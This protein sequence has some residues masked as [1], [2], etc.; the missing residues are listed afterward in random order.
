MKCKTPNEKRKT[1]LKTKRKV[2]EKQ[3]TEIENETETDNENDN[4]RWRRLLR[5]TLEEM[6]QSWVEIWETKTKDEQRYEIY[7]YYTIYKYIY[8]KL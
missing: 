1:K 2:F 8:N 7:V 6:W 5:K 3:E 4:V